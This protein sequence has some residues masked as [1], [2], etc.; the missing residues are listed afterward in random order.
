MSA[1]SNATPAK[2]SS[3]KLNNRDNLAPA[4]GSVGN[5]RHS[6]SKT[7]PPP[8]PKPPAPSKP[9]APAAGAKPATSN[10]SKLASSK[11]GMKSSSASN[12]LGSEAA[13]SSTND[14][15]GRSSLPNQGSVDVFDLDSV[16]SPTEKLSHPTAGRAKAPKRRPPSSVFVKEAVNHN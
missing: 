2:D 1:F 14:S 10:V 4:A 13:T 15:G 12:V 8:K 16:S 5:K 6:F 3:K 9:A 11:F 7:T